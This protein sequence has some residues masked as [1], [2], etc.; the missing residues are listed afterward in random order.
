MAQDEEWSKIIRY[1]KILQVACLG[2][3]V[4]DIIILIV[5]PYAVGPLAIFP[6]GDP[7]LTLL[8][9]ILGVVSVISIAFGYFLPRWKS[10]WYKQELKRLLSVQ[11]IRCS[12]FVAVAINGLILGI[13]GAGWLI[14][15]PFF[16]VATA[17]L[18][19]TFPTEE[20]WREMM[21]QGTGTAE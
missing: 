11:A 15:I 17:T 13:I 18:I 8:A 5:L 10:N 1:A 2:A 20:R 21:E 19:H 4:I 3:V 16:V 12:S 6:A 14:T 7:I 9:G